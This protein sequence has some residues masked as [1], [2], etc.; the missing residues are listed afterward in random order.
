MIDVIIPVLNEEEFLEGQAQY[1]E[2]LKDK[3]NIIFVDGGSQDKTVEFA[4]NYGKVIVSKQGRAMQKNAGVSVAVSDNLLFLH[5]D[6]L[7]DTNSLESIERALSNGVCGGCLTMSIADSAFIFRIF[8]SAVN[9]RAKFIKVMDGDLGQFVRKDVFLQLGG[10]DQVPVM[11]DILFGKKLKRIGKIK[12]LP[13]VVKVS[14][15]KWKER[16]F[17]KL[18]YQYMVSYLRLWTGRLK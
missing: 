13:N 5:V 15:R 2:E 18:L 6:S 14:S 4:K 9:L 12:V 10:Y 17:F 1:Y 16:G 11:E 7:I 8:E 3:A